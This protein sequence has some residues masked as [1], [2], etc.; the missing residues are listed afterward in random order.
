VAVRFG[1]VRLGPQDGQPEF[2]DY[3]YFAMLF[4][5]GIGVG[6]FF[7]GVSEPLWHQNS[8]WFAMPGYRSQDEVDMF[9]LNMTVFH[10]GIT[11]WSQYLV[12]AICAGLASFRFKLPM[13]LRSC[14]YPMLGEHTWGWMG[15][16]IDGFSIVATVS[17]VCTSLGL[18]A[19][20]LAA[21]LERVG[22]I[23][24]AASTRVHVIS[25]WIITLIATGSVVSGLDVGIKI[26]S[27]FGFGLGIVLLWLCFVLDKTN[28]LLNL[29][30]QEVGYYFQWSLLQLNFHTDAFGQL[31]NG[32]GRN[33][34]DG[35]AEVWWMDSWTIFYIGWWV[36]WAAFVGLFIAR[37]SK[38][39]T[40][41]SI[42]FFSYLIPLMYTI[43]W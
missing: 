37:I 26:L 2:S 20:Q 43:I 8:H 39:R 12:V 9:A 22:A 38:G 5:A 32:E 19:Y 7:F 28:Y 15:D 33:V 1:D 13:T 40:I 17:G 6:L 25:I 21:G 41:A 3:A 16:I 31:E 18:G 29:I 14:F 4:S 34:D 36:S 11:G 42:C 27:E 24:D 35:G 23:E 30:V 10:W